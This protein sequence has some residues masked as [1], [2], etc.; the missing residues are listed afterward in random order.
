M[1]SN[2][3][4]LFCDLEFTYDYRPYNTLEAMLP[5]ENSG[6]NLVASTALSKANS[7]ASEKGIMVTLGFIAALL[8]CSG[9][10]LYRSVDV[11]PIRVKRTAPNRAFVFKTNST[12]EISREKLDRL[13][14]SQ[15]IKTVSIQN[16]ISHG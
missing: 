14:S 1:K 8:F 13:A 16:A 12:A 2:R 10:Q 5:R 3:S 6:Y 7:H 15:R 9:L 11:N 4:D